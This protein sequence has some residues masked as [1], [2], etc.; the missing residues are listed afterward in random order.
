MVTANEAVVC[1]AGT[2]TVDGTVAEPMLL[3]NWMTVPPLGAGPVRVTVPEED[4]PPTTVVGLS[5]TDDS[6][7]GLMVKGAERV[8]PSVA[9]IFATV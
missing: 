9:V 4:V 3:D 7:G 6:V 1:P 5:E 8:I 2:V